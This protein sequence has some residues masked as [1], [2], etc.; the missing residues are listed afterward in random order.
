MRLLLAE[1]QTDLLEFFLVL[2]LLDAT[3]GSVDTGRSN[4][5]PGDANQELSWGVFVTCPL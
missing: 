5:H 2:N 3:F 1:Q 4:K